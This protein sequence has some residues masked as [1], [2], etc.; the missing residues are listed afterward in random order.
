MPAV[1]RITDTNAAGGIAMA[2]RPTV[3][4]SFLPLAAYMSPV[5]PHPC[6][7]VIGCS[8]HCVATIAP[9]FSTTLAENLPV[10]TVGNI[11]ICAHP[12]VTGDFTVL[13]LGNKGSVSGTAAKP[14]G[15][16]GLDFTT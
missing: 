12:R 13:D 16:Q 4:S 10:H 7:G 14:P 5:T 11:D 1:V 6:C 9:T 8:I 3:L 2:P 15:F